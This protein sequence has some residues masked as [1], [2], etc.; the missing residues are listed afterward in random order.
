MR[1]P[2]LHNGSVPTLRDLL[3]KPEARP[4]TFYRGYDVFDQENVGYV[5]TVD[6]EN[7]KEFFEYKTELSGNHNTGHLYGTNLPNED[8]DALLEYLR[9]HS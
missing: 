8:K 2:Y 9:V 5:S 1:S 4:K 6:R 3:N 7:G